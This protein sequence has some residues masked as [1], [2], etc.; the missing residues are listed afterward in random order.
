MAYFPFP[1]LLKV[2]YSTYGAYL[3]IALAM[4]NIVTDMEVQRPSF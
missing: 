3:I 1:K 2:L 4:Y